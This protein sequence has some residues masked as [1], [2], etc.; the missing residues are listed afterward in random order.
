MSIEL[1]V[2][3]KDDERKLTKQ[4]NVYEDVTF[5]EHDPILMKYIKEARDEFQGEPD[6]IVVKAMWYLS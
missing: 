1:T 3:I 5:A 2:T 6:D 4:Y